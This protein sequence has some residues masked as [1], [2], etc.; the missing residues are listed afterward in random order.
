MSD[1]IEI[2][3]ELIATARTVVALTG[4]GVSTP[5]GI[6]DFRSAESGLWSKYDPMEVATIAAFRK[7]PERFFEWMRP[8]AISTRTAR[9]NPAHEALAQMQRGGRL[10]P[11][12]TQNID[13][14]H[15]AAGSGDVLAL[16]GNSRSATCLGCGVAQKIEVIELA[17]EAESLPVCSDCGSNLV[18]PNVVLFGELLP[19]EIFARAQSACAEADLMIIAGSSLEVFPANNLPGLVVRSGGKL[20]IVNLGPTQRDEQAVCKIDAP[21]EEVLPRLV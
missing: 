4:A 11:I 20:L 17:L 14:L 10:G 3:R 5:S 16:H 6:P 19:E 1:Q 13:G 21:V 8:L 12:I 18:K 9:P 2:A 15:E 7:T